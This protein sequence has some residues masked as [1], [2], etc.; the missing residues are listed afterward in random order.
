M[1][2]LF[3]L[4]V[5]V[6]AVIGGIKGF[7]YYKVTEQLDDA[8]AMLSPFANISYEGVS[9]D[10]DGAVSVTGVKIKGYGN[11]L[12]V[13]V[14]E[15]ALKFPN[16]QTLMFIGEDL[17]K[18]VLPENMKLTLRHLRM[19]LQTLRPY[20]IMLES[21]GQQPFK[22]YSLLGCDDLIT[23]DPLSALQKLGYSELDATIAMGYEWDRASKN[24]T[25]NSQFRWHD[26]S[27]SDMVVNLG[28]IATLS[29][30]AMLSEPELKRIAVSLQDEGYNARLIEHCAAGQGVSDDDFITLHMAM[31][32]AALSEQGISL[33]EN[34]YEVYRYYLQAE[35]P[36]KL[37]MYPASMQQLANL[38]MFKPS[39][40][41]ALLGL[42][43]HMG[44]RVIRDIRFDWE[45]SKLKQAM[46]SLEPTP[47]PVAEEQSRSVTTQQ[48]APRNS[49]VEIRTSQLNEF[50][51]KDLRIKTI[52]NRRLEGALK[53]V[54]TNRIYID[55]PMGGGTA[56]LPINIAD[57]SEVKAKVEPE[58][59]QVAPIDR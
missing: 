31:L 34:L 7:I 3:L 19:D 44:D 10:L 4:V 2:K 21:Q 46:A 36:L 27:H 11:G 17:K 12:E 48:E 28:D 50:M 30:A 41:P 5:F 18:Q 14:D 13:G 55:V 54:T 38:G 45:E 15:V 1:K 35:G 23:V 25:L 42:E 32:R 56:T 59:Y 53:R 51:H 16:L 37:Q 40:L 24:F 52:D 57:I 22:D 43:I 29:A 58:A 9:S 6:A 20:M 26:M 49:Y 33:S 39:D 8:I 47:E